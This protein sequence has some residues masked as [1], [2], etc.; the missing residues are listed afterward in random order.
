MVEISRAYLLTKTKKSVPCY[1]LIIDY[2][3]FIQ[4]APSGL[5]FEN[6]APQGISGI[7]FYGLSDQFKLDKRLVTFLLRKLTSFGCKEHSLIDIPKIV[8]QGGGLNG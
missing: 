1:N 3:G 6:F 4:K 2:S 7:S 5:A 8:M